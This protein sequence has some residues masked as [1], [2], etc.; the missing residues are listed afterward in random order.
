MIHKN[1]SLKK[2][3]RPGCSLTEITSQLQEKEGKSVK[4]HYVYHHVYYISF[5]YISWLNDL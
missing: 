2:E 5:K 1:P 4:Y 3:N